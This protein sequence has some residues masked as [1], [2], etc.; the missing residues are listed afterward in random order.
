MVPHTFY[1]KR[2]QQT[3]LFAF[4]IAGGLYLLW[5]LSTGTIHL[6]MRGRNPGMVRVCRDENPKQFWMVFLWGCVV[7]AILLVWAFRHQH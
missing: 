5:C 1:G 4:A 2:G 3:M 7:E 6:R